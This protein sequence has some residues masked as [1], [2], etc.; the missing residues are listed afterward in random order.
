MLDLRYSLIIEATEDP[1]F[2]G[3]FSPQLKGFTGTGSG[4]DP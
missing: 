4:V 2:F 3:F 1:I